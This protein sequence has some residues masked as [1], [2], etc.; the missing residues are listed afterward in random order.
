MSLLDRPRLGVPLGH[1]A[2][3][4]LGWGN[5][6]FIHSLGRRISILLVGP[7]GR[8]GAHPRFKVARVVGTYRVLRRAP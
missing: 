4:R 5:A 1:S 6:A 3:V 7:L 8:L 2:G